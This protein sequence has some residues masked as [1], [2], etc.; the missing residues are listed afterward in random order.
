MLVNVL[1]SL[2]NVHIYFGKL[3]VGIQEMYWGLKSGAL[4]YQTNTP[5]APWW[6]RI[7]QCSSEVRNSKE[8]SPLYKLYRRIVE[9][10][11]R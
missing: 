9:G 7:K 1:K 4:E 5:A 2:I 3:E 8:L 10:A 11:R 6:Q